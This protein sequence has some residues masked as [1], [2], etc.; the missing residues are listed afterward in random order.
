MN[1]PSHHAMTCLHPRARSPPCMTMTWPRQDVAS[2]LLLLNSPNDIGPFAT[3]RG[4]ETTKTDV[5]FP[6]AQ[7]E[8]TTIESNDMIGRTLEYARELEKIV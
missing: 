8:D 5:I 1:P 4:W 6:E 2:R 3:A 7:A